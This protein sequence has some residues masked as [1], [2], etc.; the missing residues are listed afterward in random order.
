M[1]LVYGFSCF[2][3]VEMWNLCYASSQ[4]FPWDLDLLWKTLSFAWQTWWLAIL[5]FCILQ[6]QEWVHSSRKKGTKSDRVGWGLAAKQRRFKWDEYISSV[7]YLSN[8]WIK[9]KIVYFQIQSLLD[10]LWSWRVN[11]KRIYHFKTFWLSC[12]KPMGRKQTHIEV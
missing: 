7:L 4:M 3:F 2:A 6:C 11:N 8:R 5:F 10:F 1:F 9:E 12:A